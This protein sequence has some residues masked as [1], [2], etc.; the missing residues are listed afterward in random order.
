MTLA[1][2]SVRPDRSTSGPAGRTPLP[3][4]VQPAGSTRPGGSL[5]ALPLRVLPRRS[6]APQAPQDCLRSSTGRA[7]P[8]RAPATPATAPLLRPEAQARHGHPDTEAGCSSAMGG[9]S[10]S[11]SLKGLWG[12]RRTARSTR[13]HP[14]GRTVPLAASYRRMRGSSPR[15]STAPVAQRLGALIPRKDESRGS[16]RK[17]RAADRTRV[18]HRLP[19][20][21][22]RPVVGRRAPL[23]TA[24]L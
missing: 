12:V 9:S 14:L 16:F 23:P 13:P 10:R 20:R 6:P 17:K 7:L 2:R 19:S 4:A 24:T 11:R 15:R 5:D 21:R 8:A 18:D 22:S 1:V 3:A